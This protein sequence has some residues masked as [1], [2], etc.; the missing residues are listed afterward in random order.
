M[1]D[2][3]RRWI[4]EGK[5]ASIA[6]KLRALKASTVQQDTEETRQIS[7]PPT[8]RFEDEGFQDLLGG[9]LVPGTLAEVAGEA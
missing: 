4:N 3:S 8:L 6:D 2:R 9:G 7:L 1:I 5:S